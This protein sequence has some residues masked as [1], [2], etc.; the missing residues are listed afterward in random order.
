MNIKKI[1]TIILITLLIFW[2]SLI[3]F[4]ANSFPT[5]VNTWSDGDIIESDWANALESKIGIDGSA[6]TTSLDYLIKNSSSSTYT[7]DKTD[8]GFI[9]GDGSGW[10]LESGATAR[11]SMGLGSIATETATDYLTLA[12]YYSTTT[13]AGGTQALTV[14]GILTADGDLTFNDEIKP[15]G[16]TCSDGQI[17]K[18]N[19]NDDWDCVYEEDDSTIDY[20]INNTAAGFEDT[21]TMKTSETGDVESS[22]ASSTLPTG[23][24]QLLFGFLSD[25]AASFHTIQAGTYHLHAQFEK[26]DGTR[27]TETYWT[28]TASSTDGTQTRLLTSETVTVTDVKTQFYI[29]AATSTAYTFTTGD[30]ILLNI[31]ANVGA[32]GNAPE[33]TIYMEGNDDAHLT[34]LTPTS[35]ILDLS[36]LVDGTNA[37]SA[38]WNAGSYY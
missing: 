29:H 8:G 30:K 25:V 17:L 5:T 34:I 13:W 24:D 23:D 38:N 27:P 2:T 14:G 35:A 36:V 16:D 4:A 31:Y 10:V 21:Y 37:L 32:T 12:N 15:D 6:T 7:L 22:I 20:F 18:K 28:L 11:T 9:V 26:T 19:V 3:V 33:I 1:L